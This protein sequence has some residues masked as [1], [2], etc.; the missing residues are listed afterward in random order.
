MDSLGTSNSHFAVD[1]EF[2]DIKIVSGR[3][4]GEFYDPSGLPLPANKSLDFIASGLLGLHR[5]YHCQP[6]SH[7]ISLLQGYWG[8]IGA[9]ICQSANPWFVLLCSLCC[10][11]I[12]MQS[13]LGNLCYAVIARQSLLCGHC[14][15]MFAV[16]SLL[17]KSKRGYLCQPDPSF[18]RADFQRYFYATKVRSLLG[19]A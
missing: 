8:Y 19:K 1:R 2:E 11:V 4:L 17:C 9:T 7:W 3:G 16:Q 18:E 15:A 10:A 6:A 12:P 5:G 13:L 14:Y